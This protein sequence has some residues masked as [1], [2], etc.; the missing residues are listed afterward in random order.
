L[1]FAFFLVV[2]AVVVIVTHVP[3]RLITQ[4]VVSSSEFRL[5]SF[6]TTYDQAT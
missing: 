1:G 3:G 6:A 4:F 5:S 2:V